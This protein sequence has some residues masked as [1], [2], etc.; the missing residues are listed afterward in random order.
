MRKLSDA[1]QFTQFMFNLFKLEILKK[2]ET[3]R[4]NLEII[5][6]NMINLMKLGLGIINSIN[7]ISD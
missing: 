6:I 3:T 4:A 7:W 1:V 2:V 5:F